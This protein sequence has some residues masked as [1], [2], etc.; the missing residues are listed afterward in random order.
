LAISSRSTP[1]TTSNASLDSGDSNGEGGRVAFAD[2]LTALVALEETDEPDPAAAAVSAAVDVS[3]E[4]GTSP[5]RGQ[6][7][8]GFA[9]MRLI[10]PLEAAACLLDDAAAF[11]A[12]EEE[13]VFYSVIVAV[14]RSIG[15]DRGG[16]DECECD[17]HR[18][19]CRRAQ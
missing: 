3:V 6:S 8:N 12:D 11:P 1:A 17:E 5:R 7:S 14:V 10:L 13:T 4:D 9:G 16:G 2:A 19:F 18:R 15:R